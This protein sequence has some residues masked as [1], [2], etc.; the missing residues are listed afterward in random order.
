M[1]GVSLVVQLFQNDWGIDTFGPVHALELALPILCLTIVG[2]RYLSHWPV[3]SGFGAALLAALILTAWTGFVPI[4]LQ[5]VRQIAAHLN[6][7][8]RAPEKVGLTRAIIFAPR[9]FAPPCGGAPKHFVFFRPTNDPDL[10]N[11]IL[12]VNNVGPEENRRFVET[13]GGNK[14]GYTMRWTFSM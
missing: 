6:V 4:R 10:T 8:L 3:S 5:A 12:W 9:P 11:D 1:V 7:A 14:P 13:L 2:A